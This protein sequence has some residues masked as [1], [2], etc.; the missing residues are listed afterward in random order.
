M[1]PALLIALSLT[2]TDGDTI[3]LG[4]ERI[5]IAGIDAPE[6][7]QPRC[8][9]EKALGDK[10]TRALEWLL[11]NATVQIVRD[12]VDRYGRTLA[13][14][15]ADGVDV[16]EVLISQGLAVRWSGRRHNWCGG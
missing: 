11:H 6:T 3:R 8:A 2:V 15:Y 12:G 10:A 16:G 14:V 9:S 1:I 7:Y 13:D 5:R 4:D